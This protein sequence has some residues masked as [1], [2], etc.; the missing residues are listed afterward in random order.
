MKPGTLEFCLLFK[1]ERI[2]CL[3]ASVALKTFQELIPSEPHLH[4]ESKG[5]KEEGK[6]IRV[7]R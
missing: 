3:P 6:W 5:K 7:R 1:N 4:T 2:I